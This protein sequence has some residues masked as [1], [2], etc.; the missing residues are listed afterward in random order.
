MRSEGLLAPTQDEV[1]LR[2]LSVPDLFVQGAA[3]VQVHVRH[4][5][6]AVEVLPHLPSSGGGTGTLDTLY[7]AR[8]SDEAWLKRE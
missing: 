3:G 6:A 7:T 8:L 2:Q 5:A 4:E 1:V